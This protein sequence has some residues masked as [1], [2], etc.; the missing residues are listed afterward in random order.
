MKI[1]NRQFGLALIMATAVSACSPETPKNVIESATTDSSAVMELTAQ[2]DALEKEVG[3]VRDVNEIKRL[4]RIYGYYLDRSDWDNVLDLLTDDATGEYGNGGVY[5]GKNSIKELFYGIGYGESGLQEGQI[6][7]HIQLQPVITVAPDGMSAKG[8][9][10]VLAILGQ[11]DEYARWQAGP[12]EDEY[13]K[14]DGVWKITKLH[15]LETF[16]VPFKGAWTTKMEQINV[17]DRKIP[18]ADEPP[19]IEYEPWPGV[20]LLPYHYVNPVTGK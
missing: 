11:H 7:E 19:T 6:R 18:E 20:S 14:E 8:R 16:T 13:R 1:K 3:L 12:Y 4:Q 9:W 17:A 5:V 10:R 2:V 15:W